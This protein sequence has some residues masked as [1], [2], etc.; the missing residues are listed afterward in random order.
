MLRWIFGSAPRFVLSDTTLYRPPAEASL[1]KR[2]ADSM[3]FAPHG[4]AAQMQSIARHH[5][6]ESLR[7]SGLVG[8][9]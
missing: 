8:Y 5:Q 6:Y 4:A 7:D 2:D 3:L 9:L 1:T